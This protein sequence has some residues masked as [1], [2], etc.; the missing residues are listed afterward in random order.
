MTDRECV[1]VCG[2]RCVKVVLTKRKDDEETSSTIYNAMDHKEPVLDFQKY[3]DDNDDIENEVCDGTGSNTSS[4][5]T[6]TTAI[7]RTIS[8]IPLF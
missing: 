2:W 8:K 1:T 6:A 4:G 7:L 3:L 5:A